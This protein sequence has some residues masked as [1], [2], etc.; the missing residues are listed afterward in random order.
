MKTKNCLFLIIILLMVNACKKNGSGISYQTLG[1][2]DTSGKLNNLLKDSISPSLLSFIDSTL[3]NS[4][5]LSIKHPELFSSAGN[6][7]I[8]ITQPSDVYVT[9]V[10]SAS[11]FSNSISFYTYPTNQPP[12]NASDLKLFTY[13]FPRT[14]GDFTSLHPGDK[15]KIGRFD[16]GTTVGFALMQNA[17]DFATHNVDNNVT[18]FYT[19]DA[20]NPEV[21]PN[22]KRHAVL[23][24]YT[25]ENKVLTCFKDINRSLSTCDNDFNDIVIYCTVIH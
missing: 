22:L 13:I 10:S 9:F 7:D 24:N 19:T 14:G 3:P 8:I 1:T 21:D 20:L 6:A 2:F 17:W 12:T 23:I 25:P 4:V 15:I 16:V 18:R 11:W 5:N